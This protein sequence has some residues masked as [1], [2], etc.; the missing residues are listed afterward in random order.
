MV[1]LL[2]IALGILLTA[3][4]VLQLTLRRRW[5]RDRAEVLTVLETSPDILAAEHPTQLTARLNRVRRTE[6]IHVGYLE[7][8][9]IRERDRESTLIHLAR[10]REAAEKIHAALAASVKRRVDAGVV[11][12][13]MPGAEVAAS[14]GSDHE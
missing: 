1:S 13:S 4:A 6:A 11:T 12:P 8:E 7:H 5:V 10:A 14:V 2:L 3:M 9:N